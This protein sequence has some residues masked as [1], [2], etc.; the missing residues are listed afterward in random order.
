[1][2]KPKIVITRWSDGKTP[3]EDLAPHVQLAHQIVS[4]YGDLSPS[5]ARIM[6]ADL[7][8]AD[9]HRALTSFQASLQHVGDPNRDPRVAIANARGSVSST[10]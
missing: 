2:A 10:V 9:R 8:D 4:T 3:V 5:V 6:E 7:N 1:M